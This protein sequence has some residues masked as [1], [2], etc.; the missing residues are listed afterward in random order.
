MEWKRYGIDC[1]EFAEA[2]K[3]AL[4]NHKVKLEEVYDQ[5]ASLIY[6]YSDDFTTEDYFTIVDLVKEYGFTEEN[7]FTVIDETDCTQLR[8]YYA[9]ILYSRN[10]DGTTALGY[11][12]Q[13]ISLNCELIMSPKIGNIRIILDKQFSGTDAIGRSWG[14][15]G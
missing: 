7:G 9:E 4:P 1:F 15:L 2:V 10:S 8:M 14:I 5:K 12:E 11:N 13:A 3:A 6:D